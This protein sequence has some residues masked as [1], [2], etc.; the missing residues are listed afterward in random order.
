[1][2]KLMVNIRLKSINGNARDMPVWLLDTL[3][4]I[5]ILGPLSD[6]RVNCILFMLMLQSL[7][8]SSEMNLSEG[9]LFETLLG[10]FQTVALQFESLRNCTF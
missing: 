9:P 4:K 6:T 2:V 7:L 3:Q 5:A 8:R 10:G 1:M